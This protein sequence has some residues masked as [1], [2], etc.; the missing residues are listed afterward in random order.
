ML[1][2]ITEN[3]KNAYGVEPQVVAQAP[4][5][6]EFIGNHTDYNGGYTMGVAIDKVVMCAVAK[7]PD[8]KLCFTNLKA[9]E[10]VTTRQIR[11]K[12]GVSKSTAL[13]DVSSISRILPITVEYGAKGGYRYTDRTTVEISTGAFEALCAYAGEILSK[14]LLSEENVLRSLGEVRK[15]GG[16][17]PLLCTV[18]C[19]Y[20]E[21]DEP[22]FADFVRASYISNARSE[23]PLVSLADRS[24]VCKIAVYDTFGPENNSMKV[25]PERLAGLRVIQ[26]GGNWLDISDPHVNKGEALRLILK[27]FGIPPE[28]CAAF[29]DHMN[30]YEMLLA[31]GHP[32]VTENAFPPLKK[33]IGRT[34]PSNDEGGVL[35]ALADILES[36]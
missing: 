36:A 24:E 3:F 2:E 33:L 35:T 30:D 4:G 23:K 28:N 8:R 1:K 18:D 29:G 12:Y 9:G 22:V 25:L 15:I 20:Y 17:Y 10:K 32:Y 27:K 26:S 11:E 34:I 19:A 5:R 6:I 31:C 16:A 7:R 14:N 21:D 13:R